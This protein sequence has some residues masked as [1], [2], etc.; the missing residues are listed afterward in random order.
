MSPSHQYITLQNVIKTI[1]EY[2]SINIGSF[3]RAN[4]KSVVN[5]QHQITRFVKT[6]YCRHRGVTTMIETL[7][8]ETLT[9]RRADAKFLML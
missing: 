8:V 7:K 9:S 3:F 1:V 6:D 2:S 4:S 5:V